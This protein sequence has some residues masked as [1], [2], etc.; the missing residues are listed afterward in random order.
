MGISNE[1]ISHIA[2]LARLRVEPEELPRYAEQLGSI[3]E[4]VTKLTELDT[5]GVAELAHGAGLSNVFREDVAVP[6]D[7]EV[8]ARIVAAF[9]H[10]EGDLLEVPA[11]FEDRSE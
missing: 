4:Y 2:R 10:R 6:C 1:D 11:V 7:P 5:E 8:R 9:P 3:L